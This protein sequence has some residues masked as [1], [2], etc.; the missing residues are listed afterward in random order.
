MLLDPIVGG[1]GIIVSGGKSGDKIE[2][3]IEEADESVSVGGLEV[4]QGYQYF[5]GREHQLDALQIGNYVLIVS[6]NGRI[7]NETSFVVS[8]GKTQQALVEIGTVAAFYGS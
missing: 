2:I 6:V 3:E 4:E 8:E 1:F 7:A 5:E